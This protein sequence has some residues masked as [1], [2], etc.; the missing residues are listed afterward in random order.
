MFIAASDLTIGPSSVGAQ[1]NHVS[2]VTHCA[3]P[4]LALIFVRRFSINISSL[5]DFIQFDKSCQENKNLSVCFAERFS[6]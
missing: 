1:S 4:E 2:Q 5:R 3:P 6:P